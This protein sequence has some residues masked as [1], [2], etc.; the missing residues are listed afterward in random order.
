MSPPGDTFNTFLVE[1][2]Q[3]MRGCDAI[4]NAEKDLVFQGFPGLFI[5]IG[6]G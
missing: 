4:L 6:D 5:G 3:L 1:I 2:V